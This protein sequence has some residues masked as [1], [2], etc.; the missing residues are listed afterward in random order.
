MFPRDRGPLWR[1]LWSAPVIAVA[2]AAVLPARA[3][4]GPARAVTASTDAVLYRVFLRDGG[5]LV[6]YGDFAHVGDRVVLSIPIGGTDA[7][8]VLHLLTIAEGDVDWERTNAYAQAAR[9]RRYADTRGEDDFGRLTR[10]VADT[11]HQAGSVN[12]PAKRLA[13][14]EAARRQLVDWP[15]AHHGYRSEEL[16]QMTTWLDQ[17]VSEL[18]LA[19]GQSSFELALVARAA[20]SSPVVQLLPAPDGRERAELGLTAARK[21]PDPAERVS[22]LRAVLES[23]QPDAP[24]GSWM[25]AIRGRA[26]TELELELK[27]DAAYTALTTRTLARATRLAARADVRRLEALAQ[28]VL[29][30]DRRL[31]RARPAFVAGLLAA[32]DARIDDARRLRLARDAWVLRAGL[33]RTYWSEI[34]EGLDR[35]LGLRSWLSDVRS[36]AG[37]SPGALRRLAYEAQYAG[38]QLARVRPP[39][40]AAQAHASIAAAAGMAAR[41]ATTR[42]E[43]LRS[44]SMDQAWQASSAAAGALL[45]LDESVAEL[46]RLTN[47][48]RPGLR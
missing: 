23:L 25:A 2:L 39:A 8:P 36:L 40:E 38:H 3:D 13:L 15:A 22:L 24:A 10:E 33:L 12:D 26:A 30:E 1:L 16:A 43:A 18:R 37:P 27:T 41:A 14:A 7:N 44:G 17:V 28:T 32:L 4:A 11:L 20:P 31:Q 29:E 19:A 46:R 42:L 45:M 34:R 6:S 21:T 48:P 35:F 47:E 5:M 9:A